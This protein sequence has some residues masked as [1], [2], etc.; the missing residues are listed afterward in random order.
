MEYAKGTTVDVSKSKAE[1]EFLLRKAGAM[2]IFSGVEDAKCIAWI[3]FTMQGCPY[4]ESIKL[5]KAEH[6]THTPRGRPR[7]RESADAAHVQACKERFRGLVLLIKAK[8]LAI[9]NGDRT[10]DQEF[11]GAMM[12][13]GGKTI[14][15]QLGAQA[16]TAAATGKPIALFAD[17]AHV[18]PQ[19]TCEAQI[20]DC[21]P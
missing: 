5:P 6:F 12:L 11:F 4:R 18:G 15:E 13:P 10:W 20:I 1:I 19:D 3:M 2:N 21:K 7:N 9:T 8:L 17:F 16:A 14:Y